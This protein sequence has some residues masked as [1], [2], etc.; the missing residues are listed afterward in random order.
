MLGALAIPIAGFAES[1][2]NLAA[3]LDFLPML[4]PALPGVVFS[5]VLIFFVRPWVYLTAGLL[6][7]VLPLMVLLLFG[8]ITS[9]G[10]VVGGTSYQGLLLLVTALAF[11]LVGG[12]GGFVRERKGRQT[13][14]REALRTREGIGIALAV[15]V[16]LGMFTASGLAIS[17][18]K[19]LAAGGSYD[20]VPDE[21]LQ[22]VMKD[23]AFNP[24]ELRVAAGNLVEIQIDNQD[25][26]THTFTYEANGKT[27]NQQ[28]MG[29]SQS[30][31]LVRF[32]APQ[33]V[34]IWCI[35]HSG[36]AEDT[37]PESMIGRIIVE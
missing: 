9:L 28:V 26:A 17:G 30:R 36:G 18:A 27:F 11:S 6:N 22:L 20:V 37:D 33:T 31:V 12:I 1:G 7:A 8:E 29:M 23:H 19:T 21:T 14:L 35:P 24:K 13:Q 16:V 15:A 4:A 5:I 2:Y 34:A 10:N 32:D 3:F 25:S